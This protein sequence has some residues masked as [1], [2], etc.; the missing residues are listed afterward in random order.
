MVIRH[1]Q[2][3]P[4][5]GIISGIGSGII[6]KIQYLLTDDFTLKVVS[7][8]ATWAGCIVAFLTLI[9]WSIKISQQIKNHR[10]NK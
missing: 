3:K 7:G 6:M 1:L 10:L 5:I 8:L 2:Q 4:Q 9:G